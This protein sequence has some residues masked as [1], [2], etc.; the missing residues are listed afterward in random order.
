LETN[1][2]FEEELSLKSDCKFGEHGGDEKVTSG[3]N[4]DYYEEQYK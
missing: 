4:L 1:S 3:E 2:K